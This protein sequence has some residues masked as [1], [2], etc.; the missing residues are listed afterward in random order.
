[1][2]KFKCKQCCT[3]VSGN[4][5][6]IDT[7]CDWCGEYI[8]PTCMKDLETVY[9]GTPS[10]RGGTSGFLRVCSDCAK[11]KDFTPIKEHPFIG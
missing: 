9:S 8:C 5:D 11:R 6:F 2:N 3:E 10:S 7:K 4:I 1:M